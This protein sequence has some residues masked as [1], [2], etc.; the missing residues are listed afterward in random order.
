[1]L[2]RRIREFVTPLLDVGE[3][4]TA[5]MAGF[6]P[7]SRSLALFAV[8]PAVFAG[9]AVSSA[10]GWPAWVGGGL[11]GGT[12]A[13]LAMWLD[14]RQ[15]RADHDG[16]GLSVGLVVTDRRLFILD[17]A[18]GPLAAQ[19]TGVALTTSLDEIA[20]VE[21]V[22]MQGSGLKRAGAVLDLA[23]GTE[24]A[25]IPARHEQFLQALNRS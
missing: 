14:Q 9:F 25:V 3:E 1:V 20:S 21:T 5:A 12:G 2:N 17:L 24:V 15:A 4:I 8:F 6:R 11:G 10:A 19:P 22:K 18:T 16:K 13:G 23:D 7:L